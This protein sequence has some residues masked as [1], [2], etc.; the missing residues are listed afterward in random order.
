MN[1][2]AVKT[3]ASSGFALSL[4]LNM[5][6]MPVAAATTITISGNGSDS[7]S[8]VKFQNEREV[9]V[10]QDNDAHVDNEV[11]ADLSTGD[12]RADDNT[13]GDTKVGTGDADSKVTVNNNLNSNSAVAG[14]SNCNDGDVEVKVSGNGTDTRNEVDLELENNTKLWQENDAKVN[15]DIN[16]DA[17]TGD[18]AAKDNT[19][20][21]VEITTGDITS[22]VTVSTT[23][24][25][26]V[27]DLAGTGIGGDLSV[28]ITGNGSDSHNEVELELEN[29]TL[30]SQDNDAHIRNDVDVD[31]ES[32]DNRADDNTGGTVSIETGDAGSVVTVDNMVNF[33][34]AQTD[35]DCTL[36]DIAVKIDGNGTESH[37]EIEAELEDEL[38]AFQDNDSHLD[39]DARVD[40]ATGDN[41][42][43]DNTVGGEDPV[44]MT[45]DTDSEV[46]LG[47]SGN[48]NTLGDLSMD[49]VDFD[50]DFSFNLEGLLA[51]L[52]LVK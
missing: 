25:A 38:E 52:G 8:E 26:N 15:N 16:V 42:A 18:N 37:N 40:A 12:N 30:V 45:G 51:L 14:C 29:K 34:G 35:C 21:D 10:S 36:G 31:E 23:A 49:G 6:V 19:N 3:L 50:F 7:N 46:N 27:A 24:N 4:I 28:W 1:K 47:N 17:E 43:K 2:K 48:A 20:G 33:N 5:A 32:G 9:T 39:N 22:D 11:K 41:A 13:G 44:V